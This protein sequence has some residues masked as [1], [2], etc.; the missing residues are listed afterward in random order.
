MVISLTDLLRL[1][2]RHR[3]SIGFGALVGAALLFL[4]ALLRAPTY[5]AVATFQDVIENAKGE[6]GIRQMITDLSGEGQSQARCS[7]SLLQSR[8]V[9]EPAIRKLGFQAKITASKGDPRSFAQRIVRNLKVEALSLIRKKRLPFKER[10]RLVASD[11]DYKG[12]LPLRFFLLFTSD[13]SFDLYRDGKLWVSGCQLGE[14]ISTDHFELT[15]QSEAQVVRG[16]RYRIDLMPMHEAVEKLCKRLKVVP[17]EE[18]MNLLVLRLS[19]S[20]RH[21][22]ADLVNGVVTAFDHYLTRVE[23]KRAEEQLAYLAQRRESTLADARDLLRASADHLAQNV[24]EGHFFD[25]AAETAFLNK[26]KGRYEERLLALDLELKFLDVVCESGAQCSDLSASSP[27]I[28]NLITHIHDLRRQ[29]DAIDFALRKVGEEDDGTSVEQIEQLRALRARIAKLEEMTE[30]EEI[31][32]EVAPLSEIALGQPDPKLAYWEN[33]LRVARVE[34]KLL[35]E[36]IA[37]RKGAASEFDG[38]TMAMADQLF[39]GYS[40]KLDEVEADL[41]HLR[42][43]QQQLEDDEFEI[44]SLGGL[45]T[46]NHVFQEIMQQASHTLLALQ[47]EK[48][49][50][51]KEQER[52]REQLALQRQF[53]RLHIDQN[54]TLLEQ[55]E[56][57]L[58]EKLLSLQRTRLDLLHRD[59]SLLDGELYR[60]ARSR[61]ES[62]A[63]ERLM[64]EEQL[65]HLRSQSATLPQKWLAEQELDL[66]VRTSSSVVSSMTQMVESKNIA[67]HLNYVDAGPLDLAYPATVPNHP[68]LLLFALIGSAL[69]GSVSWAAALFRSM[70]GGIAPSADLLERMGQRVAGTLQCGDLEPLRRIR[71]AELV[72][73]AGV[74]EQLASLLSRSGHRTLVLDCSAAHDSQG[75]RPQPLS[76]KGYDYIAAGGDPTYRAEW[77]TSLRFAELLEWARKEYDRVVLSSAASPLSEEVRAL[78]DQSSSCAIVLAQE[79]MAALEPLFE[80]GGITYLFRESPATA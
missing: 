23:Q 14:R 33:A 32:A 46:T 7:L 3:R 47:D 6:M 38:V 44:S 18:D 17:D 77:L 52:L 53:L 31:D 69:G 59:L 75:V 10:G 29:R 49:R 24:G 4:L 39:V 45:L 58:R 67:A 66:C 15:F 70:M 56:A 36:R 61:K 68:H 34:A 37:Y 54:V 19:D 40:Q 80:L 43:I 13:K 2:K 71:D 76:K 64:L 26:T 63:R 48:S 41:H 5:P 42:Q 62:V 74:A 21:T 73:G 11:V 35:Q 55:T 65:A 22:A 28:K 1:L 25:T 27:A 50:T 30:K 20:D 12:E 9:L 72:V 51:P 16:R 60:M 78:I 57:L 8:A 79:S